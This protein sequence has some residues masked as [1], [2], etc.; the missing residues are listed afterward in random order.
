MAPSR[1]VDVTFI[2]NLNLELRLK[3]KSI[4]HGSYIS[5]PPDLIYPGQTIKW[6]TMA[7]GLFTGVEGEAIYEF[8]HNYLSYEINIH[9]D[10]PYIG[11][12]S[13]SGKVNNDDYE[14]SCANEG[15][16]RSHVTLKFFKKTII[17]LW[18]TETNNL[19]YISY[20]TTSEDVSSSG[21]LVQ[22]ED[23]LFCFYKSEVLSAKNDIFYITKKHESSLW[24][25]PVAVE[26]LG[27]GNS[28]LCAISYDDKI[29]IACRGYE[30]KI[31][32]ISYKEE[33]F[34]DVVCYDI[35]S[36][37]ELS[38]CIFL[39]KIHLFFK[40]E[41]KE[42]VC[43]FL[44]KEENDSYISLGKVIYWPYTL[45]RKIIYTGVGPKTIVYKGLIYMIYATPGEF[46]WHYISFDGKQW[47]YPIR[48]TKTNY[49]YAPGLAVHRGLL[50]VAFIG[51]T[52]FRK[53][54]ISDRVI[55]QYSYD[56]NSWSLPMPSSYI[57]AGE[58]INMTSYEDKLLAIYPR[59]RE[60]V[61][62][63]SIV[64]S[65]SE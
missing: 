32:L 58:S 63:D 14:I 56:G 65:H 59:A 50:K 18:Y 34:S 23:T 30:N 17:P 19:W 28:G 53:D 3:S 45:Y 47:S 39:D 51:A 7:Y 2:N 29:L 54:R 33:N 36:S 27:S 26:S 60:G 38:L 12:N 44:L 37:D 64:N 8:T 4:L 1:S 10:N 40:E 24:S 61:I 43:H 5:D 9:W 57:M 15:R 52:D 6:K 31:K 49:N 41:N 35:K 13:Y 48:F 22:Y 46:A 20:A 11:E 25:K 42:S 55:Y 16:Y 21:H 62:T